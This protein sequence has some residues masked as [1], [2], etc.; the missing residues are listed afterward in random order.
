MPA[1]RA[2]QRRPAR[3]FPRLAACLIGLCSARAACTSPRRVSICSMLSMPRQNGS[4]FG[5]RRRLPPRSLSMAWALLP[6]L[7]DPWGRAYG[8]A[9]RRAT[10]SISFGRFSEMMPARRIEFGGFGRCAAGSGA[11]GGM[12]GWVGGDWQGSRPSKSDASL[13]ALPACIGGAAAAHDKPRELA[14]RAGNRCQGPCG[15]SR[16]R[17]GA[18]SIDPVCLRRGQRAACR[19]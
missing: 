2:G 12:I 6:L 11:S 16:P 4:G 5:L 10:T 7:V 14:G 18:E 8:R 17:D 13:A 3:R 19:G 15:P 1:L 9:G